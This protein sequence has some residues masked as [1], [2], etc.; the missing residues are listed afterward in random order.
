MATKRISR[1]ELKED[2]L[3]TYYFRARHFAQRHWRTIAIAAVV[4]VGVV[5][6]ATLLARSRGRAERTAQSYWLQT[7]SELA[8]GNYESAIQLATS[9][10]ESYGST[11][12]GRKAVLVRAQAEAALGRT[13]AARE[14]F[15]E[16]A[17]RLGNDPLLRAASRRGL[18]VLL[19]EQGDPAAAADLY[20]DLA[21]TAEPVGSRIFDLSAAARCYAAAGRMEAAI[22]TLERLVERYGDSTDRV[23]SDIVRLARVKLVEYRYKRPA[24]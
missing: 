15:R 24:L 10:E 14:S 4:V 2:P 12:S 7:Q 11:R 19:E 20:A 13:D 9:L 6:A 23:P 3:V 17:E 16:A 8:Q 21:E 18:A 1:Q 22:T 5:M